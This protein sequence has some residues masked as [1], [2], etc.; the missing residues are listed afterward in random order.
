MNITLTAGGNITVPNTTLDVRVECNI[1]ADVSAFRLYTNGK[2]KN[3]D[4]FI[5]YGQ[6]QP[7]DQSIQLISEGKTTTFSVNLAKTPSSVDK[8]A[9]T[10]TLDNKKDLSSLG[11]LSISLNNNGANLVHC[12]VVIENR[13]E[14][15]LILG[16]LYRRNSEWK[17][18][19]ID[20]G[21][22]GGLKPLAELYGVEIAADVPT[23]TPIVNN[24][25]I[26]LNKVVLTKEQPSISLTK[27]VNL[28]KSE[29]FGKIRVNLNWN[30]SPQQ[31]TNS[32]FGGLFGNKNKSID[33][34][35]GAFIRFKDGDKSLVQ[36]LGNSFGNYQNH[37]FIQLENDDRTGL[38]L[39]GEWININGAKWDE[40]DEIIIFTFIYEGVP[41]WAKTDGV[42]TIHIPHQPPVETYLM[43][44]ENS[45][46]MC[47]IAR[48]KNI[49]GNI[50]VE[51][52][53]RYFSSHK[54][55]DQAYNWGFEWRAG[56]K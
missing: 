11:K 48:L 18:R 54:T 15:A 56:S 7:L 28:S 38:N 13:Q 35:L 53:D 19:F 45:N 6:K 24:S 9:F 32:L 30:Q 33:L 50:S 52:L 44:G 10:I 5:F 29:G 37:P 12:P 39:S 36:A 17:F 47:A 14:V 21:F 46:I 55:I 8:I 20:Q 1:D 34:D 43:D 41:N 23:S 42:V 2:T 4:D 3:D 49:N 25:S 40:I 31:A 27:S 51:R 22:N 26:N 16:E